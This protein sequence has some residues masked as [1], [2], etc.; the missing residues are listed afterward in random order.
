MKAKQSVLRNAY[1]VALVSLTG[2]S[3]APSFDIIGSFFPA[4]LGCLAIAIVISAVCGLLFRRVQIPLAAPVL[5][6]PCL[7]ALLTF[8]LWLIFYD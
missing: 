2:C 7:T 5:T 3:H 8:A 4:W 1:V 6:Y